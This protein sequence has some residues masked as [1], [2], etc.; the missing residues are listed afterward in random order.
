VTVKRSEEFEKYLQSIQRIAEVTKD[1]TLLARVRETF[2]RSKQMSELLVA[3]GSLDSISSQMEKYETG[4]RG[5]LEESRGIYKLARERVK[6]SRD[7]EIAS[8]KLQSIEFAREWRALKADGPTLPEE[9]AIEGIIEG[10][11]TDTADVRRAIAIMELRTLRLTMKSLGRQVRKFRFS[12]LRRSLEVRAWRF[13]WVAIVLG[14]AVNALV[15]H[16][17]LVYGIV[18]IPLALWIAQEFWI[19]P[20]LEK[21]TAEKK[22]L[23]LMRD[24]GQLP[25]TESSVLS[26]AA[27]L[28]SKLIEDH[29]TP[30]NNHSPKN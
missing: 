25:F 4:L 10:F 26:Q 28:K 6:A 18:I 7:L 13:F 21:R 29:S 17:P 30:T 1:Q 16:A 8:S 5:V 23:N 12:R 19:G 27:L 3:S 22:K 24:I 15:A 2:R 9:N 20:Y 11:H 14:V